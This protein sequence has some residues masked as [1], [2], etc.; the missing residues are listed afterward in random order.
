M[1]STGTKVCAAGSDSRRRSYW[2][3]KPSAFTLIE[4]LV[5]IAII[6]ILAAL[7]L[8]TLAR[9][10]EKAQRTACKSNMHQVGLA[11]MLYA[12]DNGD[13]FPD[14]LRNGG[15]SYHVVWM[16]T[17]SYNY[18]VSQ[19]SIATNGLTCPDK[20]SSGMWMITNVSGYRVGYSCCWG[21][22]TSMDTRPRDGNYGT[23]PWPWDSPQ[24]TT[25]VTPYSI[26]ITD[27]ISKGTDTYG[28]LVNITDAAHTPSGARTSGSNQL[29]DPSVIGSEGG[30]VGGADGSVT[31]RRQSDMHARFVFWKVPS[32]PDSSYLGYW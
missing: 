10:K 26:L 29:V 18:F 5:V 31:W 16:P 9:S 12:L 28:S 20:N 2:S 21:I 15:T 6:A 17:V 25:D 3:G 14:A 23:L 19:A 8:P 7:L 1:T 22:P 11:A 30:N 4:L 27:I 24:K 32:G 13:K